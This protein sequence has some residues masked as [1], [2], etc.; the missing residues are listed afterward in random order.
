MINPTLQIKKLSLT[1][2]IAG[3]CLA[4]RWLRQ[5]IN[6]L[7]QEWWSRMGSQELPTISVNSYL[8]ASCKYL[9]L[10]PGSHLLEEQLYQR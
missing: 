7:V 2:E 4:N 8:L 6:H 1:K 3:G 10:P 5:R 9:I